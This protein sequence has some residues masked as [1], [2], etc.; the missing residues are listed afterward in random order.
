M[1]TPLAPKSIGTFGR[2]ELIE[3]IGMG[4]MAEV[5][6]AQISAASG[7]QKRLVLKTIHPSLAESPEFVRMFLKEASLAARLNHPNIVQI[8][9]LGDIDGRHFI[10]M[11]YIPGRS[12]RQMRARV[13]KKGADKSGKLPGWFLLNAL[14]R[15]CDG[16][17]YSHDLCD[18]DGTHLGLVHRDISPENIMV[19]FAGGVKLLDFGVAKMSAIEQTHSKSLVGKFGYMSPQQA[20]GE[21]TDLRTDIY[22]IGVILYELFTGEK[23]FQGTNEAVVLHNTVQGNYAPPQEVDPTMP[24][25]L[26]RIIVKAMAYE[27]ENRHQDAAEL[28]ADL[29]AFMRSTGIACDQSHLG[30]YVS[31][32]FPESTE[33]PA[34]IRNSMSALRTPNSEPPTGSTPPFEPSPAHRT[35]PGLP[36]RPGTIPAAPPPPPSGPLGGKPPS[37]KTRPE[38]KAPPPSKKPASAVP[39][40]AEPSASGVHVPKPPPVPTLPEAADPNILELDWPDVD[41]QEILSVHTASHV[42]SPKLP[43]DDKAP[44]PISAGGHEKTP[45]SGDAPDIFTLHSRKTQ[46]SAEPP[47]PV[48]PAEWLSSAPVQKIEKVER[49]EKADEPPPPVAPAEWLSSAPVQKIE[50]AEKVEKAD[51]S[52]GFDV[53]GAARVQK[54]WGDYETTGPAPGPVRVDASAHFERGLAFV[55]EKKLEQALSEWERA[56]ELAPENRSYQVNLQ[57]LRERLKAK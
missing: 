1:T 48:A 25:E 56:T 52:Q 33:I 57:R 24:G 21:R 15:A 11:E 31:S 41:G 54:R 6:L 10:A 43:M 12:L 42:E 49:A 8:Y 5:W 34:Y 4:G 2:Y 35:K 29:T 46:P 7:F 17:H 26:A 45:V 30:M 55:R 27:P 22:A 40:R 14:A 9:E 28:Q 37:V 38:G 36:S 19:S 20:R 3:R 53:W 47:P 44:P 50:K 32:L 13:R 16:L 18:H 51:K 23:P 39:T